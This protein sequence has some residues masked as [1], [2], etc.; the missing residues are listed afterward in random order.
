MI[1]IDKISSPLFYEKS[2]ATFLKDLCDDVQVQQKKINKKKKKN[3]NVAYKYFM[4][5]CCASYHI[6]L[7]T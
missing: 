1:K 7:L 4:A 5:L 6:T 3:V 2:L